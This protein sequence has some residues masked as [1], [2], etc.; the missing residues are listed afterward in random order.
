MSRLPQISGQECAKALG[1]VGF[2]LKR[3]QGSHLVL[4]RD[5]PFAQV[6]VPNHRKLDRGT[7]HAILRQAGVSVEQLFEL[8]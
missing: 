8:L 2:V 3:Q 4:R 7:L 6:V 1:R 5:D